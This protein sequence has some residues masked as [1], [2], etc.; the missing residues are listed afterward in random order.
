MLS[1]YSRVWVGDVGFAK[2]VKHDRFRLSDQIT[3]TNTY[4]FSSDR[5]ISNRVN[6]GFHRRDVSFSIYVNG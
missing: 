4:S 6:A 5:V 1:V 3:Y 2:L